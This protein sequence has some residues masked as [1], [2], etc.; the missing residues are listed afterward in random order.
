MT[1]SD[2]M[3]KL[4]DGWPREEF[5]D[6]TIA[7]YAEQLSAYPVELVVQA[8]DD[9]LRTEKWRPSVGQITAQVAERA[10]NLPIEEEAWQIADTGDLRD[11]HGDVRRAAEH[12]GGRYA[13]L[14]S[15][16]PERLRGQFLRAYRGYRRQS[17]IDY[18]R[19]GRPALAGGVRTRALGPTM[20]ALP[21]TSRIAP[22]PVMGRLVARWAGRDLEAPNEDEVRDAIEV[23]RAGPFADDLQNDPLY[24]EAER[25][26]EEASR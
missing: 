4:R 2:A 25:I 16:Q 24:L 6:R 18:V 19:G 17:L 13:I 15:T 9:L 20:L 12:V 21:E 1:L 3:R 26:H 11:A 22:R 7:L 5:P 10:L 23:L 8:V 14:H